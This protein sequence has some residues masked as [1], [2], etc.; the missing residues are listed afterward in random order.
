MKGMHLA[1]RQRGHWLWLALA[2]G[3][4]LG[5]A[6]LRTYG[7]ESSVK[8]IPKPQNWRGVHV[9]AWGLA[10]GPEGL[11][12][13][14]EAVAKVLAP[15]GVNVIIL[16]VGYNYAYKSHPELR[17]TKFITRADAHDLVRFCRSHGIR[18][19]PQLNCLGHQSWRNTLYPL[20]TQY[21][22]LEEPPPDVDGKRWTELRSWCPLHPEVN[23][24]VFA[25]MDE[26]IDA[27][28]AD[29]FHVGMDEVLV[30]ASKNCKRCGNKNPAEVFATAVLD[31]HR[32]LVGERKVTMLMWGDRLIDANVMKYGGWSASRNGTAPAID[33]IPK[34]IV[35]CDWHYDKRTDYPSVR[36]FQDKGFRVWPASW[37]D[38]DATRALIACA[39]STAT[40]RMLGHLATSWVLEPGGFARALLG[41]RDPA[42]V[43]QR[44]IQAATA[45]RAGLEE[46]ANPGK[47]PATKTR[48]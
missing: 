16:E 22:D 17:Q 43:S 11:P 46:L 31:Y 38:Q 40:N 15:L 20:L 29:A 19:I 1:Q 36:Y 7:Q 41:Q 34:D 25:L 45:C 6:A 10:G 35:I 42:L 5:V 39:R 4:L 33:L 14:K 24:I 44:A 26:L 37:N 18:V 23:P 47:H 12:P 28:E 32:H 8:V 27:F 9:M 2:A 13:L 3:G 21:R 48:Q 30:V